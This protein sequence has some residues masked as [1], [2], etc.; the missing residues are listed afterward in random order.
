MVLEASR[1][2]GRADVLP[3]YHEAVKT[4]DVLALCESRMRRVDDPRPG[5][6]LLLSI[7]GYG[8]LAVVTDHPAGGLAI[9]HAWTVKGKVMEHIL[10]T[11]WRSRIVAAFDLEP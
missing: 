4:P 10:S 11:S 6:V 7:R 5:N 3:P 1:A 9:V 8:H 2:I